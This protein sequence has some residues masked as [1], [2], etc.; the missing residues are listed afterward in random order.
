MKYQNSKTEIVE[1]DYEDDYVFN[2]NITHNLGKMA[3]EAGLYEADA[4]A[5][6]GL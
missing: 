4:I 3:S 2:Q 6:D 5:Y 1:F